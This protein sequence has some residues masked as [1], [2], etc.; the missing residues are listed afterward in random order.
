MKSVLVRTY[1]RSCDEL[2][3]KV[4]D[5]D[6]CTV[7]ASVAKEIKAGDSLI[8]FNYDTVIERIVTNLK[9]TLR[10]G[11]DL[12]P[13]TIRFA[14]PHGSGSWP[15]GSL[16]YHVT[17]GE[18][19]LISLDHEEVKQR[20]G[21]DPLLL[22]AVP[23]KSELIFEVQEYYRASRVFEVIREQWRAVANAVGTAE[24]IVVLGYSFPKEDTYGRFFFREG[25]SMRKPLDLPLHVDFYS[26][27][28]D[29][30]AIQEVFPTAK[31]ICFKGPVTPAAV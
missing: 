22:G 9:K 26:L 21:P 6:S 23:L 11:K 15:I 1:G 28:G 18:P 30:K 14:K 20:C 27:S 4:S 24:R 25:M 8:S 3:N 12:K 29:Q 2:A 7:V 13:G 31:P 16:D 17:D 10:H 5:T 19:L